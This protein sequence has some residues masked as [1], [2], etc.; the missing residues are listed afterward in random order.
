L[1]KKVGLLPENLI[2]KVKENIS[3]VIDLDWLWD[4]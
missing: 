4:S 1:V 3:I 2:E